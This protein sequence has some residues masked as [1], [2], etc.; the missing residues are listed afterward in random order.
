M[1]IEKND[2]DINRL[3][4]WGKVYQIENSEG[5]IEALIYM[6]LLGDADV[7]RARVYALRKSAELRR[8]LLDMNSDERLSMIHDIEAMSEQDLINYVVVFSMRD[9]TNN[10][11]RE[12]RVPVPKPPKA[13]SRLPRLEKYQQEVDEYPKRRKEAVDKYIQRE[14]DKLKKELASNSKEELYKKYVTSLT[15]EFCE[16]EALRA[17]SDMEIYLGCF[18]DDEYRERFFESFEQYENLESSQKAEIKVAY[19]KLGIGMDNL[20]K[21][22]EATR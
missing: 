9:I 19:D 17:Y 1:E 21:L 15:N 22:R 10:A 20:K 2:V 13:N 3:F 16:Q 6:K 12:V 7:N 4:A 8:K 5:E 14:V 11:I 18:K